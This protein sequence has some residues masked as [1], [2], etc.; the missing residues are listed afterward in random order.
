VTRILLVEDEPSIA[1]GVRDDLQLEG[2]A[3]DLAVDGDAAAIQ[4]AQG[5]YDLILLDLMLPKKDGFSVCRELRA[6]NVHTPIIMLTALGQEVD[7][8]LGLE[9][10][11]DDYITK[12]FSRRELQSRVKAALR[13]S[14]MSIGPSGDV[15]QCSDG[16]TIDFQRCEVRRSGQAMQLTALEIKLLRAFLSR[17]GQVLTIDQLNEAAWG[18]GVFI[19]DRVVYTH[20]NNLRRKIESDPEEPRHLITMRGVGYRFDS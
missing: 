3:V 10:G 13:R 4:G 17:R 5:R 12:P 1:A 14:A 20:M 9:L 18:K 2:Y 16:L 19:T 7:K 8:V 15:H 11:A 6:A